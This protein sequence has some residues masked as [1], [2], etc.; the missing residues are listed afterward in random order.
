LPKPNRHF[1]LLLF[2]PGHNEA[3]VPQRCH[4]AELSSEKTTFQTANL[5][6]ELELSTTLHAMNKTLRYVLVSASIAAISHAAPFMAVG[7]GAELFATGMLGVRADDNIFLSHE[8]TSSMVFDLMPGVELDFGKNAQL[9]GSLTL[10]DDFVEYSNHSNLNTN[11]FSGDFVSKYDDGKSKFGANVGYHELNSNQVDA[12]TNGRLIRRDITSAGANGEAS[13][14]EITAV[15]GAIVY[16]HENYHPEGY[17]DSDTL[18]VPVNFYYKWTPKVDLSLGYQY[19][20]FQVNSGPGV[21]A[22]DHFFS[23]GARGE[24]TPLVT[25]RV[26]VGYTQRHFKDATIGGSSNRSLPG[27]DASV[28]YEFTPK[29]TLQVGVS[30]DFGTSPQ[31]QQ[32]KNF[33]LNGAVI[34]KISEEWSVNGGLSYRRIN[35]YGSAIPSQNRSD[36]YW[37]ASVGAT[38][39]VNANIK[40]NG[41]YTYRTYQTDLLNSDFNNNV[42]SVA[43][44]FRY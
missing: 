39:V 5:P 13:I 14:S 26:A 4:F 17:I 21:N 3:E 40:I 16:V 20:D 23:V 32:E 44:I 33:V 35:Y 11:L 19:R 1:S 18:T 8:K 27:V 31:G 9:Q 29:T 2:L 24:F 34:S 22:T 36:D 38:Y 10:A 41:G 37:E 42:F 12:V 7:D 28:A 6:T 25:G 30:N 15:G 43:A